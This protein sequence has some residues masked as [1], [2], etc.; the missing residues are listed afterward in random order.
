MIWR[1]GKS[2]FPDE[3]QLKLI[4]DPSREL[5]AAYGIGQLG[6]GGM[7]NGSAMGAVKDLR[8]KEGI[9]LRPTGAGSYR[10]QNSGGFGISAEGQVR[11]RKLAENAADMCDYAQAAQAVLS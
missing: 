6:W 10:W 7:I 11:W 1:R 9:S 5:Y 3:S 4:A 2:L 8:E